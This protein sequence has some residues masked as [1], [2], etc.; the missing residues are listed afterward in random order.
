MKILVD[1]N[2]SPTWIEFLAA[3]GIEA[4]H[5]SSVGKPSAPDSQILDY[6]FSNGLVLFTHDLDFGMLLAARKARGPSVIQVRTQDV[7]PSAIGG[8]L[9]SVMNVTRDHLQA[10]AIITVDLARNRIRLLPI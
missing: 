2:L 3:N 8:T 1:M 5:W 6:A 9:L 10:G 7:L 4:I